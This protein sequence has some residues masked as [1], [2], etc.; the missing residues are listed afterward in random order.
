MKMDF[1]FNCNPHDK[2]LGLF[3]PDLKPILNSTHMGLGLSWP[4]FKIDLQ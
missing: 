2:G 1:H 4:G 3:G